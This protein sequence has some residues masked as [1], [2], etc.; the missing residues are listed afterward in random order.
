MVI[1]FTVKRFIQ[2]RGRRGSR[3]EASKANTQIQIQIQI[4]K[5][6]CICVF[7][8]SKAKASSWCRSQRSWLHSLRPSRRLLCMDQWSSLKPKMKHDFFNDNR[9]KFL[10]CQ[11]PSISK[12]G[13]RLN[14]ISKRQIVVGAHVPSIWCQRHI[15]ETI[16]RDNCDQG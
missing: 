7:E 2:K 9:K 12:S 11:T 3:R 16:L 8:A 1:E 15:A 4:H 10:T 6:L 14:I 5:Y 13:P